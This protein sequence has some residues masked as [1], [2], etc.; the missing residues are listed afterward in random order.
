MLLGACSTTPL[1]NLERLYKTSLALEAR[2][3]VLLEP[4]AGAVNKACLLGRADLQPSVPRHRFSDFPLDNPVMFCEDH[5]Q[6]PGNITFQ[7]NL[8]HILLSR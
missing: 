6:L 7:D 2:T 5:S 8:L 3:H 1:P 4:G